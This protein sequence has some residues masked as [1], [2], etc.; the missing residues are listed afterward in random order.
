MTEGLDAAFRALLAGDPE[1]VLVEAEGRWLPRGRFAEVAR[2]INARLTSAGIA[3]DAPIGLIARNRP[4]H[5]AA[6]FGLL[7]ERRTIVM[8]HAYQA[9]E[10]LAAELRR[11]RLA[12]VIGAAEDWGEE[13]RAAARAVGTLALAF[14][15]AAGAP[16]SAIVEAGKG[17]HHPPQ[18]GV[19]IQMLTSGTTGTPKRVPISY[20]MLEDAV[21]DAGLATAQAGTPFNVAPYIQFYPLGNISGLY[22]LITCASHGQRIVLLERFSVD[23]WVRA[24]ETY[25]PTT[26]VS[27]PPAAIRMVLDADVPPD[28][29]RSIPAMRCGS[30]PLD[31]DL[32]RRFEQRYGIPILINYGA[33]EFCGVV[34]NWTIDDHRVFAEA[35]RGSVGRARPGIR[36]RAVDPAD[37]GPL[38]PG[39]IGQLEILAPRLSE[40]WVRT[41]DLALIDADGFLFLKGRADSMINRGGF[42]IAPDAVADMLRTHPAVREAVV[43]GISDARLGQVPAAIVEFEPGSDRPSEAE[44]AG[45]ARARLAAQMVPV[46]FMV[47]ESLPRTQSL[48]VDRG[49]ARALLE[50]EWVA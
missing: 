35:K 25:R 50:R 33:T 4:P 10:G 18:P 44:L 17:P 38:P 22:G 40:Q 21:A 13:V 34:A 42:K 3:E 1:D 8:L 16:V 6:L 32:Q 41:T 24:V 39:E 30:A 43:V 23:A 49:A 29:L 37:G 12:V 46:R 15:E 5:I 28:A 36:L 48:K 14:T 26:F 19:A 11:L 31:P 7:A 27:L 2:E 9:A 45:F 20:R 47:V